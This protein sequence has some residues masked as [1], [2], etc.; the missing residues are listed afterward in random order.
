M[1]NSENDTVLVDNIS[2]IVDVVQGSDFIT[3]PPG[4]SQL[5][6]YCSRWVTNKPLCPLNL[7]KGICNAIND[8]RCQFAKDWFH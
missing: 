6:V 2:K 1:I 5:E 7:K 3:I 4:K 8:S